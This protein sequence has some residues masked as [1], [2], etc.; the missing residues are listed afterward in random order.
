[1]IG[2]IALFG[3]KG[4]MIATGL[5]IIGTMTLMARDKKKLVEDIEKIRQA[6][7]GR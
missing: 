4:G 5:L 7:R 1:M 2:I 6:Q 3:A